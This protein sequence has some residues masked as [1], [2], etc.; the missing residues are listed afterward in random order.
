MIKD[1]KVSDRPIIVAAMTDA[2]P[3]EGVRNEEQLIVLILT[4]RRAGRVATFSTLEKGGWTGP[5]FFL[6][7][8]EDPQIDLYK[9]TYGAD[10]VV[11]FSKAAAM[12][13]TSA[14]DNFRKPGTVLYARNAAFYAA[15]YLGYRYFL[16]LDDDYD[17]FRC[18]LSHASTYT[19]SK[20]LTNLDRVFTAYLDYF[21]SLPPRVKTLC[22]AQ[23]GDFLGGPKG[24][25]VCATLPLMRKAMNSFFCDVERQFKFVGT[26]NDDVNTYI[27]RGNTGELF[28]TGTLI[29]L[30]QKE[31]QNN[32]GGLTDI[33]LEAGT[34]VKSF[35]T[36]MLCPS[37]VKV[38][39]LGV[40][41]QRL[42][43]RV[44]WP[45]AVPKILSPSH[46]KK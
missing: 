23:S 34:Y 20:S 27:A 17:S 15:Q 26:L 38:F 11:V 14:C 3:C 40:T 5:T 46:R 18:P 28:F 43:H 31:T 32:E 12:E 22:M 6:V 8:D 39:Q 25:R 9:E 19:W 21:K 1:D 10:R 2:P 30:Y 37:A 44:S 16:E 13:I 29:A 36:V 7:D 35:Y 4:N 45:F 41:H 24:N 42:H 33:Y